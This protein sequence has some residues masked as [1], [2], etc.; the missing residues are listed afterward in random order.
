MCD[1]D[2]RDKFNPENRRTDRQVIAKPTLRRYTVRQGLVR[3]NRLISRRQ[4]WWPISDLDT[5]RR[6]TQGRCARWWRCA[7]GPSSLIVRAAE[8]LDDPIDAEGL[9]ESAALL[10]VEGPFAGMSWRDW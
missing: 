1:L 4:A 9:R 7:T 10:D 5:P 2:A 3:R 6:C 8:P